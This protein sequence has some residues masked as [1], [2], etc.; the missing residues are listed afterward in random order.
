MGKA[1][2]KLF[3]GLAKGWKIWL[4]S[5]TSNINSMRGAVFSRGNI[6]ESPNVLERVN[7]ASANGS[8]SKTFRILNAKKGA[9]QEKISNQKSRK[10]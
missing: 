8:F 4:I 2:R 7:E 6:A 10:E 5:S 9:S 3:P 1:S